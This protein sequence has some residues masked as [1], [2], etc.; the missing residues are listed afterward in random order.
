LNEVVNASWQEFDLKEKLWT[1]PKERMKGTD[2]KARPHAVPLTD[3]MLAILESLPRFKRGDF[4]FSL[5][6]GARPAAVDDKI[7]IKIDAKMLR[8][9]RALARMRGEDPTKVKLGPWVNH[10]LRR[11][12]RSGLSRLKVDHDVKEAVLAHAKPGI[13]GVYDRYDLLDEKR[14]ALKK[15]AAHLRDIVQPLP[16]NVVKLSGR[17]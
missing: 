4:L 6:L 1:I 14:K 11:T 3:Q 9:L 5:S 7:K 10:D 12:V 17:A 8:S 16:A 13:A 15:W 2:E